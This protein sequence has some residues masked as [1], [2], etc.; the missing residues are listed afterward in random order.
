MKMKFTIYGDKAEL[1][2][3]YTLIM[4]ITVYQ[5]HQLKTKTTFKESLPELCSLLWSM[6]PQFSKT[7][8]FKVFD[9]ESLT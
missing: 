8:K 2:K 7:L 6:F 9:S 3:M 1:F 4:V 5:K